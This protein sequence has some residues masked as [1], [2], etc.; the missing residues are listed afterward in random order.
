ML[1]VGVGG[2]RRVPGT[3]DA[4]PRRRAA[5]RRARGQRPRRARQEPR[6][7]TSLVDEQVL[8]GVADARAL[9]LGVHAEALGH[10]E[11]GGGVDVEVADALEVLDHRDAR[12]LVVMARLIVSPPRG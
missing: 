8:D 4:R 2:G 7:A 10:L 12:A 5:R 9:H 3:I 11:V 6:G 1:P